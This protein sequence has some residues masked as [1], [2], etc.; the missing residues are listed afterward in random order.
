M[1]MII[2]TNHLDRCIATLESSLNLLQATPTDSIQYEVFRNAVVKGFE[3]T[4][5]TSGKLLRR[6][7]KSYGGS[8]RNIDQLFYKDLLRH[9]GKHGLMDI[10]AVERWC[11][12]RDNRNST[13]HDYGQGFAEDTLKLLPSFIGDARTLSSMLRER[14]S[15]SNRDA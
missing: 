14:F 1:Y 7:L 11:A 12:Y 4:L 6:A 15:E 2:N 8:P 10:D 3:L 9:A 5:E 13:A